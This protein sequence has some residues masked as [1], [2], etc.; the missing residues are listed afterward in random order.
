[1]ADKN[2]GGA[3]AGRDRLSA[4]DREVLNAD[5][6]S[7]RLV[8]NTTGEYSIDRAREGFEKAFADETKETSE[9]EEG[10]GQK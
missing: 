6:Q 1:M 8:S 3:A 5:G 2:A 9:E 10:E 7:A 4:E